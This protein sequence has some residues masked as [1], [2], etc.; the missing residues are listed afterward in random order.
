MSQHAERLRQPP[1]RERVGR[2]ALMVQR[3]T[4]DEPFVKQVRIEGRE[5]FG[6][7]HALVDQR[8]AGQRTDVEVANVFL[9]R[10]VLDP[11]PDDEQVALEFFHIRVGGPFDHDL[12]DLG[13]RGGRFFSQGRKI[14][15]NLAPA[16]NGITELQ[17]FSL[18]DKPAAFLGFQI[19]A[20]QECHTHRNRPVAGGV[21]G[22]ADM[23][24]EKVLRDFDQDAGAVPGH[25][26]GID[27]ASVPQR[28]QS[29]DP[30]FDNL[31]A[32]LAVDRGDQ[33]DAAGIAPVGI[34][35]RFVLQQGGVALEAL[36][37]GLC[38]VRC[39]PAGVVTICHSS[40]SAATAVSA[41]A[42]AL[43]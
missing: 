23:I 17:D 38:G 1:R 42:S 20:R 41:D 8:P 29:L 36:D 7:E 6:Q 27:R 33:T 2:I 34:H 16:I 10:A 30:G 37:E 11:L 25:A 22:A 35:A 5:L 12:L 40:Y 32:R 14:D 3:E 13:P 39:V 9:A 19:G 21:T 18:N 28:L 15:R 43:I 31:A 4:R 24:A 26:V